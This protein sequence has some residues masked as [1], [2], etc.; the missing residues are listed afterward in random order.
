MTE[1]DRDGFLALYVQICE[2]Y[3][4]PAS[5]GVASMWWELARRET[6]LPEFAQAAMLHCRTSKFAPQLSEILDLVRTQH[7]PAPEEAWNAAPKTDAEA[8]WMCHETAI[9]M[10]ACQDSIDRGDMIG[11]RKAFLETY[12]AQLRTARG[13]PQWWMSEASLGDYETRLYAKVRALESHPVRRPELTHD[14]RLQ[15][16]VT[17]GL[18]RTGTGLLGLDSILASTSLSRTN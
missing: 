9:A 5:P 18:S 1:Q 15:L 11:A 7:W 14:A 6:S 8:G 10:A 4:R 16:E 12:T 3:G 17:T 13:K 2:F